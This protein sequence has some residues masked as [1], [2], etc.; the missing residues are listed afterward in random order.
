MEETI[1][2]KE[3]FQVLRKRM[4]MIISI[5][6]AAALVSAIVSFFFI[7]PI[8]ESSTQILV[9]QKKQVNGVQ[10]SDVQT[11]LQL[12]STYAGIIK[13]PAILDK[14]KSNLSL[15]MSTEQLNGKVTVASQK[16]SQIIAVKVQDPNPKVARDIANSVAD[17]FKQEV[18]N[19]M[20]V[21]NVTVLSKAETAVGQGPVKPK[22]TLNVM[23]ALVVGFMISVGLAF[24]LEYLDNTIK[25]EQD[26]ETFLELPVLGVIAQMEEKKLIEN[27]IHSHTKAREHTIGS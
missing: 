18:P 19:I 27:V 5:T 22:P 4:S 9:N 10:S 21:D 17:V 11:N 24:L 13:S 20:S 26:I 23:I 2:L 12:I 6:F 3:L 25:K 16:D 7:T 15:K 8:Y 14:V 1:S